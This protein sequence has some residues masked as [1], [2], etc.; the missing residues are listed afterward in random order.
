MFRAKTLNWFLAALA[1]AAIA[2]A[3]DA[4]PQ[5]TYK[6]GGGVTQPQ[7]L[8]KIEPAYT[9][10]ARRAGIEGTVELSI[11]VDKDGSVR[12]PRVAKSVD[13]GLDQMAIQAVKQ[14]TFKP[15]EKEGVPVPVIATVQV[16]FR[17]L[18]T[19]AQPVS[20]EKLSAAAEVLEAQN[21][22]WAAQAIVNQLRL[23]LQQQLD[24]SFDQQMPKAFDRNLIAADLQQLKNELVRRFTARFMAGYKKVAAQAY[25]ETF[26]LEELRD[27]TALYKTPL[28]Q[29][30]ARKTPE[31]T[32]RSVLATR[33]L[34]TEI[35]QEDQKMIGDWIEVMKKKYAVQ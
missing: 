15:G 10:E 21:A 31:L 13:D 18:P 25:A 22:D 29:V 23:L 3:Q 33:P 19:P 24:A 6:I 2:N 11:V 12:E 35:L 32:A 17:L 16:N 20:P 4:A 7:L 34:S 26:T 30:M 5:Q 1:F 9:E 8:H 14:W 28:G 27:L